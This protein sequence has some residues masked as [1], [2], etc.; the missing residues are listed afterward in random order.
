MAAHRVNFTKAALVAIQPPL[1]PLDKRGKGSI[2]DTYYDTREKGLALLVTNAGSKTF[3]LYVK[4]AGRP[5][6]I[7]LGSANDLSIEQARR[8]ATQRRGEIAHG[9]NPQIA[10]RAFRQEST[11]GEMFEE[12]M[13]RYSKKTK[14]SWK[15]DERE[16]KKF[17]P[18][19]FSR[20]ISTITTQEVQRLHERVRNENGLY[21]AN[22]LLERVRAMYN[23]VIEWGWSG[24]NPALGIRKF[25]E[26]A[27]DR[28]LLSNELPVFF[29][30]V[31]AEQNEMARDYLNLALL[32]GARKTNILSMQW[33]DIDLGQAQWRIPD[34]KNGDAVVIALSSMAMEIVT[35]RHMAAFNPWVFPSDASRFGYLQDP[36]K[37]WQRLKARAELY[38]LINALGDKLKW[39]SGKRTNAIADIEHN[40][41]GSLQAYRELAL[42]HKIDTTSLGLPNIRLHDL[43][44]TMGSWQAI[45]GASSLVIGKSLGHKSQ[46]ATAIYARLNLDPIRAS[47]EL[48]TAAMMNASAIRSPK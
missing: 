41:T 28:F 48:A 43:R 39:N 29:Q 2:F 7:R 27:R 18:H 23:K 22:R 4:I 12:Y 21:Q 19:W 32:T 17:L 33:K 15:Y 35:R 26:T 47:I 42:K 46:Q 25:K 36:K 10:K 38:Q 11:F 3:Y 1:R 6:R 20:K 40:L 24:R 8:L 30:A 5:E 37:A 45:T 9:I 16:I 31:A 44:R 34:T 14:K 13:E